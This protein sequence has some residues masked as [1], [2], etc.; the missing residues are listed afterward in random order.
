MRPGR[1]RFNRYLL[2]TETLLQQA[3]KA[4]NPALWLYQNNARTS[5]F[6]LEALA[7]LHRGLHNPKKFD[8]I[9]EHCKLLEDGI[10]AIDYYDN[11]AKD[12]Q[13]VA[14][15]PEFVIAYI[16]AQTREKVQRLNDILTEN[17]WT[18]ED[19][20]RLSK[21]REKLDEAEWMK[22]EKEI[23]GIRSFYEESIREIISFM[24]DR[25][26][27]MESQ[28]HEMRRKLRWLSIYPQALQGAIQFSDNG[29]TDPL[30]V[31]Y[32]TTEI[33]ESPFNRLPPPAQNP[34]ILRFEKKYFLCLSWMIAELGRI[35]DEGLTI[36]ATAEALAQIARMKHHDAVKEA[37]RLLNKDQHCLDQLLDKATIICQQFFREK[38][39]NK[40]ILDIFPN[41]AVRETEAI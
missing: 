33:V 11:A 30:T 41:P 28:V 21:I 1:T 16:Q 36:M 19:A 12:L 2:E 6:M 40:L 35:K 10:G 29:E 34:Y 15:M 26:T 31:P 27:E 8:K 4:V 22:A 25:F 9:K 38:H 13:Q 17:K 14:G 5:F 37:C 20:R 7:K 32:L 39:F 24:P 18:G 3:F 23:A